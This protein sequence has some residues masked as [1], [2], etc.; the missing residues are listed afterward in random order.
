MKTQVNPIAIVAV[1]IA[2]VGLVG[3]LFY[4]G[5]ATPEPVPM[6]P[7]GPAAKLL[8]GPSRPHGATPDVPADK[9]QTP[10]PPAAAPGK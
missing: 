3:Y 10:Q 4:K 7:L 6:S 9:Q 1:L 5:T 2:V 8:K